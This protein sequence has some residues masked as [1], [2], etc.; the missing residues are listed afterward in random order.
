[1]SAGSPS[2][3]GEVRGALPLPAETPLEAALHAVSAG[4][5]VTPGTWR[6]SSGWAGA[7]NASQLVPVD[8]DFYRHPLRTSAAVAAR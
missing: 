5:P 2:G 1:M 6:G 8:A 4:W 3:A 7:A